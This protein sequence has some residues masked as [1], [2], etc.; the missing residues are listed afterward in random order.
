MQG[1]LRLKLAERKGQS[2]LKDASV[3]AVSF[4][5]LASL[6]SCPHNFFLRT[7]TL[8]EFLLSTENR[9]HRLQCSFTV[10]PN[11]CFFSS[12]L[13]LFIEDTIL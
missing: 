2:H 10:F 1:A 8:E 6:V 9:Y 4:N 7:V 3:A 5:S 13:N 11:K 12:L